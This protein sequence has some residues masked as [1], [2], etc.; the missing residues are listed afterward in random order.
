[1]NNFGNSIDKTTSIEYNGDTGQKAENYERKDGLTMG[2]GFGIEESEKRLNELIHRI[3]D[4]DLMMKID[5]AI[6][7]LSVAYQREG[8]KQILA[9]LQKFVSS[10]S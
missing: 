9:D 10:R 4:K 6:G 3:Q 7:D 5:S 2:K 1:M 8:E